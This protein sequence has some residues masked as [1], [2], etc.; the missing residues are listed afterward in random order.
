ME[1]VLLDICFSHSSK[2]RT[3]KKQEDK[4]RNVFIL[5]GTQQINEVNMSVQALK[6][7][8]PTLI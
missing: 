5:A 8:L 2:I 6:L 3:A 1:M 7:T 4:K